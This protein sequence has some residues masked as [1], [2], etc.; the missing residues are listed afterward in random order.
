MLSDQRKCNS[1]LYEVSLM[2]KFTY[3]A[4]VVSEDVAVK[5]LTKLRKKPGTRESRYTD[6]LADI[7][8]DVQ[9]GKAIRFESGKK[10]V[11]GIRQAI[12]AK[13]GK[14]KYTCKSAA[15]G[16]P[17]IVLVVVSLAK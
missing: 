9:K 3:S 12:N 4:Q 2:S 5:E 11:A 10:Y 13:F 7:A 8:K 6:L 14:D 1:K 16:K 15:S 17:G